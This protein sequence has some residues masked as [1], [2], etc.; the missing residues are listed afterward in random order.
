MALDDSTSCSFCASVRNGAGASSTS[1]WW[2]RC[3][4][5]SRVE[6]TTTVPCSSARHCVSTCRGR[7]RYRSTKHSPRPN[8]ATAS[9]TADS[10]ISSISSTVRATFRPRPPPPNAALIAIGRPCSAANAWISATPS[11]GS[12]VPATR[13]APARCAMCRA[14]TLSPSDSM[15]DGRRTDPGEPGVDDRLRE[16]GVLGE[17]A[18]PGVHGVRAGPTGHVE[19]LGDV[20][21]GLRRAGAAERERLVGDADVHG[22]PVGVGVDGDG[23]DRRVATGTGDADGDLTA[24]GDEDLG[25]DG[26]GSP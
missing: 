10:N 19:Q 16:R 18:V 13:G 15:A 3:S 9:R 4:E 20:E 17:E 23:A 24:V 26:H 1:F 22:L 21:V 6:T 2:R 8:A 12:G 5:Q 25:D 14:L 11:T 7:S